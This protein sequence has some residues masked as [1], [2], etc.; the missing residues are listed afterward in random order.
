M[1]Y[2]NKKNVRIILVVFFVLLAAAMVLGGRLLVVNHPLGQVDAIIVLGGGS[3]E[4]IAHGVDLFNKNLADTLIISGCAGGTD[5]YGAL[6]MRQTAMNMG[7]PDSSILLDVLEGH[8]PGTGDQA[9]TLRQM[10]QQF[11]FHSAIVV[12]SNYHTGR[13][14]FIFDRAFKNTGIHLIISHPEQSAFNPTYWW[15]SRANIRIFVWEVIKTV[16]YWLTFK[17]Q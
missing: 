7:I 16:W 17:G 12:T 3:N 9:I 10:M 5:V 8:S 1:K 2:I 13:V 6:R 11:N 14:R 4:R 15:T